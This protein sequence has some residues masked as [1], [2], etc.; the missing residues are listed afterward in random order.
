MLVFAGPMLKSA[1]QLLW[2]TTF[3]LVIGY[4]V[5]MIYNILQ[6]EVLCDA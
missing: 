2:H 4:A 6:P 5:S 3:Q 1:A